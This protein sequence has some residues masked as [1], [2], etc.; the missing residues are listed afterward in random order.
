MGVVVQVRLLFRAIRESEEAAE[1]LGIHAMFNKMMPL[2]FGCST[3]RR[4]F[5]RP[6]H[7]ASCRTMSLLALSIESISLRIMKG[8][9]DGARVALSCLFQ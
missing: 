9:G 3:A 4:N 6:I 7:P 1:A 5:L 2:P 8:D